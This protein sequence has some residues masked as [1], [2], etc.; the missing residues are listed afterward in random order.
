MGIHLIYKGHLELFI[1]FNLNIKS[2]SPWSID[3]GFSSL[4]IIHYRNI[5]YSAAHL[6]FYTQS[7]ED[8]SILSNRGGFILFFNIEACC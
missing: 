7:A 3:K 8:W 6:L 1:T 5:L 4:S 2:V